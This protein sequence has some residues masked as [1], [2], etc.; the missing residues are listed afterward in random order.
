LGGVNS[1]SL[2]QVFPMGAV[3]PVG[4]TGAVPAGA[5]ATDQGKILRAPG[6]GD[7][8]GLATQRDFV[9]PDGARK[10]GLSEP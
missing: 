9:C 1:M 3:T 7:R 10:D 2:R 4:K 6:A 8:A 5:Q